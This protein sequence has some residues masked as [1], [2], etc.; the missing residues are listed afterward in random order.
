M[1]YLS[2]I[3]LNP[4]R[5]GAQRLL[6]NPHR[7]HAAVL[8]GL[9]RQPVSE[10]VLWRLDTT[11]HRATLLVLTQSTPSW[12]HLIEQAGWAAADEPQAEVR[13]YEP[14][15]NRIER[16]REFHFRLRANPVSSTMHPQKPSEAQRRRLDAAGRSRG[17]RVAHRSAP[18]QLAWLIKHTEKWGF[19][20]PHTT[21]GDPDVRIQHRDR[22]VFFK[23]TTP[24]AKRVVIQTATF[25][26]RLRIDDPDLART[27]LLE[28]VGAARAYGCGLIT[29]APLPSQHPANTQARGTHP[30]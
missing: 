6:N 15:L 28:G 19:T 1:P 17:V 29:L 27:R 16:G 12:E 18:H 23:N 10:R 2:R 24:A 3:Y 7:L 25:E 5:S 4:L 21:D 13:S 30:T 22:L 20:I 26:G 14:L 11:V 9:S 8:G